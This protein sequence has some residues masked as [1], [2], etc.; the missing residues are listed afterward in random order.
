LAADTHPYSG[1]HRW[2]I[3]DRWDVCAGRDGV[4]PY[5]NEE[6]ALS[7]ICRSVLLSSVASAKEDARDTTH[8]RLPLDKPGALSLSNGQAGSYTAL[9]ASIA[10]RRYL[11]QRDVFV[12]RNAQA[13]FQL[14][15][16]IVRSAVLQPALGAHERGLKHR[17]T[18]NQLRH[19][20]AIF[21]AALCTGRAAA[22][23]MW[24]R[25]RDPRKRG[26]NELM[27]GRDADRLREWRWWLKRAGRNLDIIWQATPVGGAW[28]LQF[29]LHNFAPALQKVVVEQRQPDG[30]WVTLHGLPLIEFRAFAAR[31]RTRIRREFSVP[32]AVD[33]LVGARSC[34]PGHSAWAKAGRALYDGRSKPAP[35]Q[36]NSRGER[37]ETADL[38]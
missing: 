14:R 33:A 20:A 2:Q 19:E 8:H 31:P 26:P 17:T 3:N 6:K 35:L 25:S 37:I 7:R 22:R 11:A 18:L 15:R 34:L 10:F 1:Y 12:R 32:V 36:S 24:N 4:P 27:L 30:T 23:T 5:V 16:E 28:Q 21:T 9:T 13:V 29:T 38:R